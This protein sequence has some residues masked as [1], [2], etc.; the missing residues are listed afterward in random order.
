MTVTTE[1]ATQMVETDA[2]R[3]RRLLMVAYSQ[4]QGDAFRDDLP[5]EKHL[6]VWFSVGELREIA[7]LVG[8]DDH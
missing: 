5:D 2:D 8:T 3:M 6:R 1:D 7:E 4:W